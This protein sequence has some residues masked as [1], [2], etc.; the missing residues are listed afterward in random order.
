MLF[1]CRDYQALIT[2]DAWSVIKEQATLSRASIKNIINAQRYSNG[3][4][5]NFESI[6]SK[7]NQLD[8][9]NKILKCWELISK[10]LN[11]SIDPVKAWNTIYDTA[12]KKLLGHVGEI[13][14]ILLQSIYPLIKNSTLSSDVYNCETARICLIFFPCIACIA[15]HKIN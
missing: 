7:L 8:N 6:E 12:L 9:L 5:I 14:M 2:S 1:C 13:P 11:D 3:L 10:N 4:N 15:Y